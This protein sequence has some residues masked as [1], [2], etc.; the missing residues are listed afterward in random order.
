MR[1]TRKAKELW[2]RWFKKY[3]PEEFL[4]DF[5]RNVEGARSECQYCG[6]PST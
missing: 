5:L 3:G 4:K 2:L 1:P 6:D